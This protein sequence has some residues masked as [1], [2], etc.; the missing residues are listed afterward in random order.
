MSKEIRSV[1]ITI[2]FLIFIY[3]LSFLGTGI[4]IDIRYDGLGFSMLNLTL[5]DHI[6]N[7]FTIFE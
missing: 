2:V 3:L 1:L 4:D 5:S 6:Q 7:S